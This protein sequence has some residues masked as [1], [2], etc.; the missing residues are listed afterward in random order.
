MQDLTAKLTAK[1]SNQNKPYRPSDQRI[2]LHLCYGEIGIPA[3]AAAARYLSGVGNAGLQH[4][5]SEP[6]CRGAAIA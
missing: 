4:A 2:A 6:E 3:V 1:T 5:V